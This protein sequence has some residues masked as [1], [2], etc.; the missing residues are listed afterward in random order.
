MTDTNFAKTISDFWEAAGKTTSYAQKDLFQVS[1][2]YVV[3]LGGAIA[4]IG[5]VLGGLKG[6]PQKLPTDEAS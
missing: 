5:N 4:A 6:R 3:T 2:G 1:I